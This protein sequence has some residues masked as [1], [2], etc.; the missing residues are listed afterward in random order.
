[1]LVAPCLA[2]ACVATPPLEVP[3]TVVSSAWSI[4]VAESQA[5]TATDLASLLGSPQLAELIDRARAQSPTLLAARARIDQAFAQLRIARGAALP[6]LSVGTSIA[7]TGKNFGGALD[8]ASNFATIDAGLSLD[9]GGGAAAGR[10]SAAARARAAAYDLRALDIA[11]TTE[12]A[13]AFVARAALRARISLSDRSIAQA[14]ELQRIVELRKR[15]GVAT[16]VDVGLE[17]VRVGQLRLDRERLQ[18]SFDQTR[19]AIALLVGEEAPG[20][21]SVPAEI[22]GFSLGSV[23][24]PPPSRLIA[25]RP[26]VQAAEARIAAAGGDVA[27]AR[28]AFFPR[29][30][31]SVARGATLLT[32]G[33]LSGLTI[34][35]DL[36]APIFARNRLKGNLAAAAAA[37][38]ESVQAY[39]A[40]L[41]GALG[42]VENALAAA[43]HARARGTILATLERQARRTV[44]LARDQYLEGEADLRHLLDAQDYLIAAQDAG[45]VNRQE[46]LD[47]AILLFKVSCT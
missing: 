9:L 38:R 11:V 21:H 37:Q 22:E 4:S 33:A 8:F 10:R 13:R 46:R 19:V 1:M 14:L 17:A 12:L 36:L 30:D 47:A 39:R 16:D 7:G 26:D 27:Q 6:T 34:G 31:L 44:D 18:E 41:F 35:A 28:A 5:D 23:V 45:L 43:A 40:V 25:S 20:F 15:E 24:L 2:G 3:P 29:L 42:D 32:G